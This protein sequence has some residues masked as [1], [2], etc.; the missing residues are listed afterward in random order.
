[1]RKTTRIFIEHLHLNSIFYCQ[2]KPNAIS[3]ISIILVFGGAEYDKNQLEC[4]S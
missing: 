2:I 3:V 1:M 4:C